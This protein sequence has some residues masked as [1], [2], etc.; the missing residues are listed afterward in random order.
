M[1]RFIDSARAVRY[2]ANA[3]QGRPIIGMAMLI[4]GSRVSVSTEWVIV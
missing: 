4:R 3:S 1:G 2:F